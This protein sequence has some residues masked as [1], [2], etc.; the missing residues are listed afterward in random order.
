M[1]KLTRQEAQ[2]VIQEAYRLKGLYRGAR[3]GQTIWWCYGEISNL[4]E[5]IKEKLFDLIDVDRAT[6][7]DFYYWDDEVAITNKF[8]ELYVEQ[9]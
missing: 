8:Y 2:E 4:P 9:Y 1:Q 6:D 7:N 5:E 3:L